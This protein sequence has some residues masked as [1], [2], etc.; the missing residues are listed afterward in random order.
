MRLKYTFYFKSEFGIEYL[1]CQYFCARF[2]FD[3]KCATGDGQTDFSFCCNFGSR[4]FKYCNHIYPFVWNSIVTPIAWCRFM[5]KCMYL[6]G[7]WSMVSLWVLKEC[8]QFRKMIHPVMTFWHSIRFKGI[9]RSKVLQICP[10]RLFAIQVSIA[11]SVKLFLKNYG[12]V[13][14]TC[15]VIRRG[16]AHYINIHIPGL[17]MYIILLTEYWNGT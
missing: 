9:V 11:R 2:T 17:L 3:Y 4:V 13:T 14:N 1:Q 7:F 12:V 16:T 6:F 10:N 5:L 15:L 8:V